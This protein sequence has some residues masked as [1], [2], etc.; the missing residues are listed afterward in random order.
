MVKQIGRFSAPLQG[1][2]TG[3]TSMIPGGAV[4]GS[5]INKGI[6]YLGSQA[7][8]GI[9]RKIGGFGSKMQDVSEDMGG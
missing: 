1:V 7:A 8:Q 6:G 2:V 9:A 5:L 3:L 4:V